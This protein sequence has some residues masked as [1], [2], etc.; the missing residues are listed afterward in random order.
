MLVILA[1]ALK[2]Q[3]PILRDFGIEIVAIGAAVI[4]MLLHAKDVEADLDDVEWSLVFFFVGLFVVIGVM[5]RA[6][7]LLMI[8]ELLKQAVDVFC[9]VAVLTQG[10]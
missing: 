2:P 10:L 4:M 1:F 3:I 8:G 7:V 9:T 5:E 6:G